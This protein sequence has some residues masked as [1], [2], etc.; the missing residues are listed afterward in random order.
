MMMGTGVTYWIGAKPMCCFADSCA[1]DVVMLR[2]DESLYFANARFLEDRVLELVSDRST[3][4]PVS[5]KQIGAVVG[6]CAADGVIIGAT[7][8]S[9]PGLNNVL[10]FAPPLIATADDIDQIVDAV[11]RSLTKVFA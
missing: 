11:D 6:A 8:R 5:E 10:C 4:E 1:P 2:V 9:N 7:N 3:K